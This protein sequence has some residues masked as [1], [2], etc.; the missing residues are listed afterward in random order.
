MFGV[1]AAEIARVNGM[2]V[3]SKLRPGTE[4]AVPRAATR[5]AAIRGPSSGKSGAPSLPGSSYRIQKGDTLSAVAARHST[6]VDAIKALN[7]LSTNRLS[8]GQVI[9]VTASSDE[10]SPQ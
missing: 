5:S 10:S 9:R 2:T 3:K 6:T 8:I 4:L 7:G 1:P